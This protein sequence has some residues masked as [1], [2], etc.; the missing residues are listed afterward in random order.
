MAVLIGHRCYFL[1]QPGRKRTENN[2]R[3]I[4]MESE[5]EE[6]LTPPDFFHFR[7]RRSATSLCLITGVI[8]T[9]VNYSDSSIESGAAAPLPD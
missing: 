1:L 9:L 5:S 8:T 7:T 6:G 3:D 4:L 2:Q